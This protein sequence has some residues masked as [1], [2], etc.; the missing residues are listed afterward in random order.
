MTYGN[1]GSDPTGGQNSDLLSA[2]QRIVGAATAGNA[3]RS[4][5]V[6]ISDWGSFL[7][8]ELPYGQIDPKQLR[9]GVIQRAGLAKAQFDWNDI[10]S[11]SDF[12]QVMHWQFGQDMC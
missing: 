11:G 7:L 3:I 9:R 8:G 12:D 1:T 5:S 10:A 4:R 2:V 6:D